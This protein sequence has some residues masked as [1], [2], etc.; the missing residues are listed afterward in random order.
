MLVDLAKHVANA[1][2]QQG[3]DRTEVL[4]SVLKGFKM[5]RDFPT[6]DGHRV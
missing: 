4:Q 2:A 6:D 3:W 5:E 1:Y